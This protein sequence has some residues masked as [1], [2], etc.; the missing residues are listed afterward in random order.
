MPNKKLSCDKCL[1]P[2]AEQDRGRAEE[3]L[4]EI[5][6]ELS[7]VLEIYEHIPTKRELSGDQELRRLLGL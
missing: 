3:A 1:K 2:V 4:A 5:Q 6:L 7:E